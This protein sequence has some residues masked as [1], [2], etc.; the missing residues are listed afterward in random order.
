MYTYRVQWYVAS[1]V[2]VAKKIRTRVLPSWKRDEASIY[3]QL[4]L[5]INTLQKHTPAKQLPKKIHICHKLWPSFISHSISILLTKKAC[6]Y[7]S[8]RLNANWSLWWILKRRKKTN[9]FRSNRW[10]IYFH[11]TLITNESTIWCLWIN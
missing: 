11:F 5:S 6:W 1:N 3:I 8:L 7:S 2:L 4:L 9:Q 10:V